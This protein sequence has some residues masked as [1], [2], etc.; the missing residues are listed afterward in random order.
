MKKLYRRKTRELSATRLPPDRL[1]LILFVTDGS[2][3]STVDLLTAYPVPEGVRFRVLHA[4]ER[5]GKMAAMN[6]AMTQVQ[7]PLVVFSDA[8]TRLNTG[9][10]RELARHFG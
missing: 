6:R 7:T 4:P 5:R 1:S 8:N 10:L 3:D 9:A 2:T